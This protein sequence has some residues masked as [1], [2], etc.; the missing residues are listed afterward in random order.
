MR[1]ELS[2]RRVDN[3]IFADISNDNAIMKTYY[4]CKG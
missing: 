3:W 1:I 4:F 2:T